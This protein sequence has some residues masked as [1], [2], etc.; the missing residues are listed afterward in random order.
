MATVFLSYSRGDE[1]RVRLL[2]SAL[3]RAGHIVWW[4][5]HI[6]GGDEY[7]NAIEKALETADAVVVAWSEASVKSA[8]VRDEAAAGRDS[9]RL[10]PVTLDGCPPPLGFRQYQT[11]DLSSWTGRAGARQ[12]TTLK[13]A[14]AAK[15]ARK[16]GAEAEAKPAKIALPRGRRTWVAAAA[17]AVLLIAAGLFYPRIGLLAGSGSLAPRVALA[18]FE[19]SSGLSRDLA[20]AMNEEILA[21]FGA[22]N[23]VAVTTAGVSGGKSAPFV[24]S[25]SIRKIDE[26]L[27]FTVNLKDSRTGMVI[28]S[29]A[30]DRAAADPLAPR[31]VSV[32]ASQVVRCGLWGASSYPQRMPDPALSLYLQYCSET[33][34]GSAD[35]QR[36]FDSAK[37][38]TAAVPDFSFGWSAL[39]MAAVPL[40]HRAG[41]A[42]AT[43][44]RK[45]ATDAAEQASRLD[46]LNPEGYMALAGL[47]PLDRFA[48]RE[49]L[50]TKAIS[51][52]PTECGCERMAYGDFLTSVGRV[53]EAVEQYQRAQAMMPL[54][55]FTNVRLSQALFVV[56]RHQDGQRILER[57][58]DIWPDATTLR[59]LK[60]KSAYWT[61][62]YELAIPMLSEPGLHLTDRQRDVLA[63]SFRALAGGGP[64]AREQ[65]AA[66]L[67]EMA[68]DPRRNDRLVVAALAALG[69]DEAALE[70]ARALIRERGPTLADVL[71]E[72][73][74]AAASATPHY[75]ALVRQL[76]LVGYWQS[77]RE[78]P[79]VCRQAEKPVFCTA[80]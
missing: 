34:G 3:E 14:V 12:L 80:A 17:I 76:G 53:E 67:G 5:K 28:W 10:V 52:R 59:V 1:P 8:W 63:L 32:A 74:L 41:S 62:R 29:Q 61:R 43:A 57:T 13:D 73:N 42:E 78:V 68:A 77:T 40:S 38:V 72:P 23:A 70:A 33:W 27:R 31:Q 37:R 45:L 60:L 66:A 19:L 51:V 58:L 56:G 75:V 11:I 20:R 71:F 39:A 7:A 54:A 50:L 36:I 24:L 21:A 47:L 18:Q 2:A 9:G 49:Q 65:A 4:D 44:L 35:E 55:P 16:R 46:P 26:A 79:D 22:E 64:P 48:K 6:P 30:F 25:G 15:G 69:A